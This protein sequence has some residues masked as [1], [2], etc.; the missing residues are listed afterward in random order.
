M[1]MA[2]PAGLLEKIA[3]ERSRVIA[4]FVFTGILVALVVSE[5]VAVPLAK[6]VIVWNIFAL[7]GLAFLTFAL[8]GQRIEPRWGNHILAAIWVAPVIGTLLSGA[9]TDLTRLMPVI[10]VECLAAAVLLDTRVVVVL[11]LVLDAACLAIISRIDDADVAIYGLTLLLTQ[12]FTVMFHRIHRQWIVRTEEHRYFEQQTSNKLA[13][14]LKQLERSEAARSKLHDQLV[15]AQRMEAIG[16][17]AAGLAHDMNNILASITS[18]ASLLREEIDDNR[19]HGDLDRII[20]QASRGGELT[21][22]LLAFSRR[23]QYRK[24]VLALDAVV[25]EVVPIL[26]RTL[27]KSIEVRSTSVEGWVDGDPSQLQQVI[28]NLAMNAADAMDGKGTLHIET[29]HV[30]Y[31]I[32]ESAHGL[33]PGTYVCLRVRDEGCGMDE[34]TLRRVFEPFFTTKPLGRGTGLGLATVWGIVQAH[35]GAVDVTSTVGVGSTFTVYL[36][37]ANAPVAEEVD[38]KPLA[39]TRRTTVL[40]VDDEEMVRESTMRLLRR[41]GLD[42]VGARNGLEAL[43]VFKTRANEIGLVVLDMAMPVMGGAECFHELRKSNDVPVLIATGYAADGDAQRLTSE[44][45][46]L[47]EKPFAARQLFDEVARLIPAS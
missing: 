38:S 32:D 40:V 37:I 13:D 28:I 5:F 9:Y 16:T 43:E 45:A 34:A 30:T 2:V 31:A 33:G 17:L 3:Y 36:P 15:H 11:L 8:R 6:P 18:F 44:G 27:P 1:A 4:P 47:I 42:T 14:Q 24:R 25:R 23:G 22:A 39:P 19:A 20:S 21:R 7:A 35:G 10:L 29:A 26:T 12:L 41:R 46:V